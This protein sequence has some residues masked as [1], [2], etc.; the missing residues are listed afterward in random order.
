MGAL[1]AG[2]PRAERRMLRAAAAASGRIAACGPAGA[3]T[4]LLL[5]LGE[6]ELTQSVQLTRRQCLPGQ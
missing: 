1:V 2:A 6:E 3:F 4:G 5:G